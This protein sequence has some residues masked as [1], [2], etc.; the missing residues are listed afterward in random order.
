M[1][2]ERNFFN[3]VLLVGL[4]LS[5]IAVYDLTFGDTPYAI[6]LL[7]MTIISFG[8]LYLRRP[9]YFALT[10]RYPM[11]SYADKISSKILVYI[12]ISIVISWI[13]GVLLGLF[14]QVPAELVFRNFFG[15]LVY[16]IFP[17][18]LLIRPSPKQLIITV[19][20]AGLVQAVYG[21]QA[22]FEMIQ[23][24]SLFIIE[25]SVSDSR[26]FYST[27]LV[28]LFPLFSISIAHFIL[29]RRIYI[30]NYSSKIIN[31]TNKVIFLIIIMYALIV[32]AMSKG[33]ILALFMLI[34][35]FIA[36]S[37]YYTVKTGIINVRTIIIVCI[38]LF[39]F[40]YLFSN[41]YNIISYSYGS[42]EISNSRRSE[43]YYYLMSDLTWIGHG[44]GASL[45]SGYTRDGGYGMELTYLNIMHKLGLFSIF[46]FL[47]Y[48]LTLF[49]AISRIMR[50]VRVFESVFVLGSMGYLVVGAGNPILL[51]T[52][53]VTLHSIGMYIL[54]IPFLKPIK[55][56]S[57]NTS[58]LEKHGYS[59]FS[60]KLQYCKRLQ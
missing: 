53:G 28:I 39:I 24:P 4:F 23:N 6:L 49:V 7:S 51:S 60:N 36:L 12:W 32:P 30:N 37:F 3:K 27:G 47:S 45:S 17:Y 9:I 38:T 8:V 15:L 18:L 43:Q 16:M 44:L 25:N 50:C 29:P 10:F 26:T 42:D 20:L 58:Q 22:S 14:N 33:F 59:D 56:A 57:W 54:V 34:T 13:Y 48:L 21:I 11:F 35:F 52:V 5:L 1:C 55:K 19:I 46:L 41:Y 2:Y 40:I 31:S